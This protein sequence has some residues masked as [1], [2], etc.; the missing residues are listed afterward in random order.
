MP[1]VKYSILLPSYN[2]AENLKILLPRLIASADEHLLSYEIIVLD[3]ETSLDNSAEI[4]AMANIIYA[5]RA[6]ANY[7]GDALRTGI[8]RARGEFIISMDADG[9]HPPEFLAEFIKQTGDYDVL[10]ASRYIPGGYTE[11]NAVL[12]WMSKLLNLI[13]YKIL[14]IPVYDISNSFRCYRAEKLRSL[15][16]E[17]NNFDILQ[18]ILIALIHQTPAIKIKEIPFHFQKRIA[19]KSKRRLSVFIY[20]YLKTLFKLYK[21]HRKQISLLTKS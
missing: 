10:I 1:E 4:C 13:Y 9:S 12:V 3:A 11:N 2:E 8:E 21:L 15:K 20:S 18:E 16:L 5:N 19:G 6:P 17:C 7:Y 14:K